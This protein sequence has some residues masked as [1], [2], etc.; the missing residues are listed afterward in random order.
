MSDWVCQAEGVFAKVWART[1]QL[2]LPQ[3][4]SKALFADLGTR[5]VHPQI[6]LNQVLETAKIVQGPVPVT[7]FEK[8]FYTKLRSTSIPISRAWS[9]VVFAW[10][11]PTFVVRYRTRPY[12]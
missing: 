1:V 12:L 2:D 4:D 11:I 9:V 5:R 8:C 10:Q 3:T 7:V 6:P